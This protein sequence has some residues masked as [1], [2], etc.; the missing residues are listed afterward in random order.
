[1]R[2]FVTI[3]LLVFLCVGCASVKNDNIHNICLSNIQ[4]TKVCPEAKLIMDKVINS[5]YDCR[6]NNFP[7]DSNRDLGLIKIE[8]RLYGQGTLDIL[9][10]SQDDIV[11][12]KNLVKGLKRVNGNNYFAKIPLDNIHT[13]DTLSF[14]SKICINLPVQLK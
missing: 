12:L 6:P 5:G 4:L 13:I 14:V 3:I 2:N 8:G 9:E 7:L 11:R 1:M 10:K